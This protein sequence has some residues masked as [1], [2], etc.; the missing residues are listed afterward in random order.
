MLQL[1][2]YLLFNGNAEAAFVFYQSILG[3]ELRDIQRYQNIELPEGVFL[4]EQ[5]RNAV[6]HVSLVISPTIRL[7]GADFVKAYNQTS[8]AG[9]VAGSNHYISINLHN[10]ETEA[11]RLFNLLSVGGL[12]ET[13]LSKTFWGALY[14]AFIDQFGIKWM[15]NCHLDDMGVGIAEPI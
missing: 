3:G 11:R 6:L 4:T 15:I 12:V 5:E 7:M 8:H 1:N 10:D 13:Q 14:G 2:H 9:Y